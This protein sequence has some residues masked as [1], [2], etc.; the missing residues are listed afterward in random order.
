M[1]NVPLVE[2]GW[3][4]DAPEDADIDVLMSWLPDARSVD[5]WGGPRFRFPFT[6]ESFREDCRVDEIL[7]YC[8]RQPDGEM[9]AFGQVYDR[10]DRGHLARL[11]THPEKRR[12]GIGRRLIA[13]LIKAAQRV[14]GHTEYSLF[15]Y[16]D[17]EPA[18]R[19]YLETGFVLQEYPDDAPM[20]E[21]CFFLT[22]SA[23]LKGS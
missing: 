3:K 13:L 7:S 10:H 22:R 4:L 21:K 9:V 16:R 11:I 17:N 23:E 12:Q 14:C 1:A 19:C 20:A 2:D 6:A 18:Y 5:I 8:L 15:V